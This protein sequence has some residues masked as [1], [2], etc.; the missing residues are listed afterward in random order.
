M[1]SLFGLCMWEFG[2]VSVSV[3]CKALQCRS[4]LNDVHKS[5]AWVCHCW[6]EITHYLLVIII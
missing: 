4:L 1:F 5:S 3:N 2:A 6:E